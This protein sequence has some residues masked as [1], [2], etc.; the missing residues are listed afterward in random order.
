MFSF[1]L[2]WKDVPHM[3]QTRKHAK[4]FQ[5]NNF[6]ELGQCIATKLKLLKIQ[7]FVWF[8]TLKF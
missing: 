4:T 5:E 7:T 3:R 6:Q 1:G 8:F 2:I